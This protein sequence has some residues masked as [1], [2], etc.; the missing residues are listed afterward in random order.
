MS[1][2]QKQENE[3]ADENQTEKEG[4]GEGE[5]SPGDEGAEDSGQEGDSSEAEENL[6]KGDSDDLSEHS[7][8][9]EKKPE[10]SAVKDLQKL[11]GAKWAEPIA[12]FEQRWTWLESRL[13]TFVLIWQLISLVLW[14]L[15]SG[16][17]SPPTEG[18]SAGAVFRSTIFAIILG[19]AAFFAFKKSSE[20]KRQYAVIGG[21]VAGIL[22]GLVLRPPAEATGGIRLAV[23]KALA[24]DRADAAIVHFFGNMKSWLQDGST[25]T[26]MG[27]LRGLATRLTL[28]LALL[29][30]S[31]ATA[32]GKHI[33]IDLIFR[34]LPKRFRVPAAIVNFSAAALV[35][36]T[37]TWGFFDHIAIESFG[38]KAEDTAG[39]K[40]SRSL[41]EIGK[42]A[43]LTRKQIGLD[44]R[45]LPHVLKAERYDH[46]MSP[47][48]WN[49]WVKD[50]GF[51]D[52]FNKEEIQGILVPEVSD[53]HTPL[54]ISPDGEGTR[55]MLTHDLGLVFPFGLL[56]IGIRFLLRALLTIS[57]HIPADPDAAH[58]LESQNE[59][60]AAAKESQAQEGAKA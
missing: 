30:G 13:L 14:V 38:S 44:L 55:G 50:A 26:L 53:P 21:L 43:F 32:A 12:G 51:E 11:K 3:S 2:D 10:T 20:E 22:I 7:A 17:A 27:G 36:F 47:A 46:W 52:H 49:E 54:V 9:A 15:L 16:L 35:C 29:G 58:K 5:P 33:H 37:A 4:S 23:N 28:W 39:S 57:G 24:L 18:D 25:L 56:M 45:T 40:I 42:H 6:S 31:L 59:P 34:F 60:E 19:I 41:H 8:E 1:S 48:I